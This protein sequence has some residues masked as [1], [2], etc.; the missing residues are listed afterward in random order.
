MLHSSDSKT[1]TANTRKQHK[2]AQFVCLPFSE[3]C[4]AKRLQ[5]CAHYMITIVQLTSVNCSQARKS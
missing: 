5:L 2:M 3:M 1:S 4:D